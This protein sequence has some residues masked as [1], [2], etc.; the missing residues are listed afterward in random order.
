MPF[1][2]IGFIRFASDG[3]VTFGATGNTKPNTPTL[4]A[5]TPTATGVTLTGSAFSDP[6]VGDTHAASQWQ[7]T[8]S[9]DT[10]YAATVISTG[11]DATNKTSYAAT[12]LTASTPYIARVRY[13]D[14]A[15]NYSSYSSNASFTTAASGASALFRDDFTGTDG[16]LAQ[17]HT[18]T[19][20]G[21]AGIGTGWTRIGTV[22]SAIQTNRMYGGIGND[23]Q[24]RSTDAMGT[25]DYAETWVVR[26]MSTS[27]LVFELWSRMSSDGLNGYRLTCNP[28]T[29]NWQFRRTVAGAAQLV[30]GSPADFADTWTVGTDRTVVFT[31]SGSSLT[32]T[33][34]GTLRFSA[35][36]T[37][38]PTGQYVGW[39]NG[40]G[41]ASGIHI[42]SVSVA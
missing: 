6:D 10:G 25:N 17:S 4:S 16:T 26:L 35:T 21:G 22:D 5:G 20:G 39:L 14:S 12:G 2:G 28:G 9:A 37:T 36:D 41:P 7:V 24:Y 11:D 32:V 40:A 15:G 29:G 3:A 13:K 18:P 1:V 38:L 23:S 19:W 8:T 34:D 42:D 31:V 33:I 30:T 27:F